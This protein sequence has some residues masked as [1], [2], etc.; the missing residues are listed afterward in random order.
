MCN[1]VILWF[2]GQVVFDN[3]F[4]VLL[5]YWHKLNALS[6]DLSRL[7][8]NVMQGAFQVG[9]RHAPEA[10][11]T[12]NHLIVNLLK[13]NEKKPGL[14]KIVKDRVLPILLSFESR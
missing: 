8:P 13:D 10:G 11:S 2:A 14:I 9:N 5:P 4:A 6:Y 1:R 7:I 12:Q 3:D